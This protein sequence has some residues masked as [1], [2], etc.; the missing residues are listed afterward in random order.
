MPVITLYRE[1]L[2][3]MVGQGLDFK[4]LVGRLP[5]LGLHVEEATDELVKVE[6][7]PNRLDYSTDYGVA[8]ALRGSFDLQLGAP[9]HVLGKSGIKFLVEP[10]V[11]EVRPFIAGLLA[12][13]LRLDDETIRQIISMQEDLHNGMGRKRAKL[14]I[15]IHDASAVKPPITYTTVSASFR[16]TPLDSDVPMTIKEILTRLPTGKKYAALVSAHD[17]YPL[18]KDSAGTVLSFPPIINGTATKV[19]RRTK[20]LLIDVT[21]T[22]AGVLEDSLSILA[23][24]FWDAGGK[25]S[26]VALHEGKSVRRTPALRDSAMTLTNA[27]ISDRLGLKFK[28][29]EIAAAL[30][31][32]RLDAAIRKNGITVTIPSYRF[33]ILHPLDLAEEVMYGYGFKRFSPSYDFGYT[34]G[35][36]S[37]RT[38]L[39]EAVRRTAT[40]MGLQEAMGYSLTSREVLY[41]RM[42]RKESSAL[43][44][45]ASKSSLYEYLR[46]LL[47]PTLLQVLSDNTHEQYPQRIFEA[48][49]V[50]SPAP[51]TETG[52]KEELHL[53]GVLTDNTSS[54]TD[55]KSALETILVRTF[56][57]KV[58]CNPLSSPFLIDGRGA[59]CL[60]HGKE[61]GFVGEVS[62]AV[63]LAFGLRNP[64]SVFEVSLEPF[65]PSVVFQERV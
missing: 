60:Y 22:D 10:S 12:T 41:E 9:K 48:A 57:A 59:S 21:G 17:A 30:K 39:I 25:V 8:R 52:V 33:D 51:G 55:A 13:G 28:D 26:S 37:P 20:D 5:Y 63:V 23:E 29:A 34:K 36:L 19:T 64:V 2:T 65:Y 7:D 61:I 31:R 16:F 11:K 14:A 42:S 54:F 3:R 15:G 4:E 62:P 38:H 27:L 35:S 18:I 58:K 56:N 32:S 53:A 43:K 44:V 24:A 1:R 40:G 50:F 47:A 6:Y 46:D 49:E 45:S